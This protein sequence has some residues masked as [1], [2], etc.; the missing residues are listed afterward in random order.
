MGK[1]V[2]HT[3]MQQF[4]TEHSIDILPTQNVNSPRLKDSEFADGRAVIQVQAIS[5]W[6]GVCSSF[7]IGNWP[8]YG[9]NNLEVGRTPILPGPRYFR[10]G[11]VNNNAGRKLRRKLLPLAPLYCFYFQYL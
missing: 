1:E 11:V 2:T 10:C 3:E 6:R 9:E 7:T 5:T 8:L 4:V